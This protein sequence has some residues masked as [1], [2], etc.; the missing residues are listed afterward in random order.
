MCRGCDRHFRLVS[1]V[2][3]WDNK[4]LDQQKSFVKLG[5]VKRASGRRRPVKVLYPAQ[6]RKYLPPKK[7][8]WVKRM[9]LVL[10]SIVAVQVYEATE[11]NEDLDKSLALP[12]V[13][14]HVM[15][16]PPINGSAFLM[17]SQMVVGNCCPT[18]RGQRWTIVESAGQLS[19]GNGSSPHQDVA[20]GLP[21]PLR[22]TVDLRV[23]R[24]SVPKSSP[25]VQ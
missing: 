13:P 14:V 17:P 9:L 22:I 10:M 6:V 18:A 2:P 1:T 3:G 11:D 20:G 21:N 23:K 4:L 8:D 24:G 19:G 16:L 25:H 5:Q 7:K 15:P 12:T